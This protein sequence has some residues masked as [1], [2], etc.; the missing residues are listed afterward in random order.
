MKQ[1]RR[2]QSNMERP[3]IHG[4]SG[5]MSPR[6][7]LN[8]NKGISCMLDNVDIILRLKLSHTVF[9]IWEAVPP[10]PPPSIPLVPTPMCESNLIQ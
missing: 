3:N 5:G 6:K 9:G 2:K 8:K 1:G 4:G 10:P 7:L